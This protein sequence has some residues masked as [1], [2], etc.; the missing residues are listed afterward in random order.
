[1]ADEIDRYNADVERYNA[2]VDREN[3]GHESLFTDAERQL[4]VMLVTKAWVEIRDDSEMKAEAKELE[5]I[6]RKISGVDKLLVVRS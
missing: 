2:Q 6:L 3:R 4:L 5:G 1:M